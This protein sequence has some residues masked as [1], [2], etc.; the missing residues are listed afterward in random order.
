M[1]ERG[2]H[3][4]LGA[5][6]A[7]PSLGRQ[8]VERGLDLR[9]QVVDPQQHRAELGGLERDEDLRD[10][11][12][13]G[14][15]IDDLITLTELQRRAEAG[16]RRDLIRYERTAALDGLL[17]RG[18]VLVSGEADTRDLRCHRR[19]DAVPL[20]HIDTHDRGDYA[21]AWR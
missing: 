20:P 15:P 13:L 2:A 4:P 19:P 17:A 14:R 11:P 5:T 7:I 9:G 1:V 12:P 18:P 8:S 21:R 6:A 10:E 3:A 16:I